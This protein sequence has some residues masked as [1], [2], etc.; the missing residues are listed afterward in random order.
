MAKDWKLIAEGLN[1]GIPDSEWEKIEV[2]LKELDLAFQPLLQCLSP[3]TEP[4]FHFECD[5]EEQL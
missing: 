3:V 2:V 1:L 4:A 5:R